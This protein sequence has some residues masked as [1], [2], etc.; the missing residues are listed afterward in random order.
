MNSNMTTTEIWDKYKDFF[1]EISLFK[2]FTLDEIKDCIDSCNPQVI[3]IAKNEDYKLP[4]DLNDLYIGYSGH[5]NIIQDS[6]MNASLVHLLM[7]GQI[8]GIASCSNGIP[9]SHAL[10]GMKKSVVISLNYQGLMSNEATKVRILENLLSI[11]A[12]NLSLMANKIDHTQSRSVRVKISI[13]LRDQMRANDSNVIKMTMNR[14]ET[15][16]YLNITYPAMIREFRQ[17]Q[18]EN[19]IT[20]DNDV[21]TII[22]K[23]KLIDEGTDYSLL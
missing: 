23:E 2:N 8:F 17:M 14:K 7:P 20:I 10:F 21:I 9:C 3:I 18:D 16:N 4:R 1:A 11:T 13:F 6:G 19:I 22:D 12:N 15:A 5:I